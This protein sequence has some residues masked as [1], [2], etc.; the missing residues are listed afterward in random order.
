[1]ATAG[2]AAS[3]IVCSRK[4]AQCSRTVVSRPPS[5]PSAMPN[6]SSVWP[7]ASFLS[8]PTTMQAI[9]TST[10][11]S[12]SGNGCQ[13]AFRR[14]GRWVAGRG[15]LGGTCGLVDFGRR[16]RLLRCLVTD[17][18]TNLDPPPGA[19]HAGNDLVGGAARETQLA[20]AMRTPL[21]SLAIRCPPLFFVQFL[22]LLG[23]DARR[24]DVVIAQ[25]HS[26]PVCPG[27]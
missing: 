6:A 4:P 10:L 17:S 7:A 13:G 23:A 3:T 9:P 21:Y 11:N 25:V 26:S 15:A 5:A 19:E 20:V 12:T 27:S 8:R 22:V 2:N 24:P 18:P 1:M 14:S 16:R